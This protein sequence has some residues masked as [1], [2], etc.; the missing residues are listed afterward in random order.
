MFSNKKTKPLE[1]EKVGREDMAAEGVSLNHIS[2]ETSDLHRLANFYRE[3]TQLFIVNPT[4]SHS[5]SIV[6]LYCIMMGLFC[7]VIWVGGS[8]KPQVRRF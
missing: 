5:Y 7:A 6:L 4:P 2:R 3:V 8:R 1:K